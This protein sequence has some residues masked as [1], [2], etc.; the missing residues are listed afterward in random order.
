ML[1]ECKITRTCGKSDIAC[2][3]VNLKL[4]MPVQACT[5]LYR[6]AQ[7]WKSLYKK[8]VIILMHDIYYDW[9]LISKAV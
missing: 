5:S 4:L 2:V 9:P 6:L 1:L 7:A 3:H 8:F